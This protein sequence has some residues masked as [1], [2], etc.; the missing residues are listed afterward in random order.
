[1]HS[2]YSLCSMIKL[3]SYNN[4][5]RCKDMASGLQ[6]SQTLIIGSHENDIQHTH[7][8]CYL[9]IITL[10]YENGVSYNTNNNSVM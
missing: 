7:I 1:M 4:I 10:I 8:M 9:T 3:N 2:K 6:S 5:I